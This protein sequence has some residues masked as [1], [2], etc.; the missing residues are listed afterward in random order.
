MRVLV[1]MDK[2]WAQIRPKMLIIVVTNENIGPFFEFR[3]VHL[4]LKVNVKIRMIRTFHC[5][6]AYF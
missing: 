5:Y 2:L 4:K 6:V 3:W 1:Q